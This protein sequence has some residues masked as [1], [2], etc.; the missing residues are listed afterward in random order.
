M[1][2]PRKLKHLSIFQDGE[3]W[4]SVAEDWP[5]GQAESEIRGLSRRRYDGAP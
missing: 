4:I 3:N 5:L 1:A 2:L